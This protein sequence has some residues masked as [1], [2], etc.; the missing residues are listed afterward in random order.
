MEGRRLNQRLHSLV[1][2]PVRRRVLLQNAGL[3]W[4]ANLKSLWLFS[5]NCGGALK[6]FVSW[7]ESF[8]AD[9][10]SFCKIL[11]A[12]YHK[13][14]DL[15][16]VGCRF[17]ESRRPGLSSAFNPREGLLVF[18]RVDGSVIPSPKQMMSITPQKI[19]DRL[20]LF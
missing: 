3:A 10:P 11:A 16:Y 20:H 4:D 8:S 1:W 6:F 18:L 2:K 15:C 17:G 19:H 14:I 12:E 9:D 7:F 5:C 13:M